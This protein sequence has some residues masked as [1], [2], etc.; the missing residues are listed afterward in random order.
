M[1]VPTILL[2]AL[3]FL[4][5]GAAYCTDCPFQYTG[6]PT[7]KDLA[8]HACPFNNLTGTCTSTWD[9]PPSSYIFI[10]GS[11]TNGHMQYS[12]TTAKGIIGVVQYSSDLPGQCFSDDACTIPSSPANGLVY[13][14]KE[15]ICTL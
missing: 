15:Y 3:V 2:S 1:R 8:F 10:D 4:I 11:K 7:T 14:H 5:S 9:L 13:L 12:R 6:V